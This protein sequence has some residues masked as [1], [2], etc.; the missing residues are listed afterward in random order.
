MV[1]VPSK[2]TDK[3]CLLGAGNHTY[4]SNCTYIDRVILFASSPRA[5]VLAPS[6]TTPQYNIFSMMKNLRISV[7]KNFIYLVLCQMRGT[8]LLGWKGRRRRTYY[9]SRQS[10]VYRYPLQGCNIRPKRHCFRH[11]GISY[12]SELREPLLSQTAIQVSQILRRNPG[13]SI[14]EGAYQGLSGM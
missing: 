12:N 6:F 2:C 7:C 8:R 1:K 13:R 14:A 4:L 9:N 3:C 10:H 5:P 11:L